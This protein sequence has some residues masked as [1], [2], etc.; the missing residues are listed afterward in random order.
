M[1]LFQ[2]PVVITNKAVL[3]I[4][5][6]KILLYGRHPNRFFLLLFTVHVYLSVPVSELRWEAALVIFEIGDEGFIVVEFKVGSYLLDV[7]I[8]IGKSRF[9]A[10]YKKSVYQ[11]LCPHA[12]AGLAYS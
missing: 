4:F 8:G 11:L 2:L 1:D 5:Y 10:R 12:K 6:Y 7:F 3:C 9:G